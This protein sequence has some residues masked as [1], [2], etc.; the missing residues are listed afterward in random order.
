MLRVI[1]GAFTLFL[2]LVL[3]FY[4]GDMVWRER[5]L[6]MSEM[7]DALPVRD[8]VHWASKLCALAG[9]LAAML[10]GVLVT[11]VAVQAFRGF[12][13]FELGLYFQGLFL[14]AMPQFLFLA[15]LVCSS[16]HG[17]QQ[18]RGLARVGPRLHRGFVLPALRLEHHL[19]LRH[20]ARRPYPT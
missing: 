8:W 6:R 9:V 10:A 1:L 7:F 4:S 2:F 3:T 11:S 19:Y 5:N 15:V 20:G 12:T 18:V 16:G 13:H 17:G 14:V